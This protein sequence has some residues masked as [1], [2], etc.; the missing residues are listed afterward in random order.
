MLHVGGFTPWWFKYTMD[1]PGCGTKCKHGGVATEW[2]YG[3][4][5]ENFDRFSPHF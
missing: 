2:E 3:S 1:G 4:F 5:G